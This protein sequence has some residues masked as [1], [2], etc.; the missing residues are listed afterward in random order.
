MKSD[1]IYGC[2][3]AR[4]AQNLCIKGGGGNLLP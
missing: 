4:E 2:D 1:R 3:V